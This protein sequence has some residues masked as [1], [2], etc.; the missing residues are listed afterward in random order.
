[1]NFFGGGEVPPI[2]PD[3]PVDP[4]NPDPEP[5]LPDRKFKDLPLYM[6][7]SYFNRLY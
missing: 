1:M 2:P 6:Y 7:P 5:D 3:P 4:G